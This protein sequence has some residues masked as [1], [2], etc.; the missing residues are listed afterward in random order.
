MESA[1]K[2]VT[3]VD[4]LVEKKITESSLSISSINLR[5]VIKEEYDSLMKEAQKSYEKIDKKL[6]E[7]RETFVQEFFMRERIGST[8]LPT[9][10]KRLQINV[11]A[12]LINTP[13]NE[14]CLHFLNHV[15]TSN[16]RRLVEYRQGYVTFY[17]N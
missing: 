5:G 7:L 12:E 2:L 9:G 13:V 16:T 1:N 6:M 14:L 10:E 17:A 8:F 11:V 4:E 15:K 3:R